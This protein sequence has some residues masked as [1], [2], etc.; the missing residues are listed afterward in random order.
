MHSNHRPHSNFLST[1]QI[2]FLF[3]VYS[4]LVENEN[5]IDAMK[6]IYVEFIPNPTGRT[7]H[8]D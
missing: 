4:I 2:G 3:L 5:P 7:S 8:F 1:R 6:D